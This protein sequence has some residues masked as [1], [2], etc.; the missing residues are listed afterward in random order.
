MK[1]SVRPEREEW[2]RLQRASRVAGESLSRFLIRGGLQLADRVLAGSP[3]GLAL[4]MRDDSEWPKIPG[5]FL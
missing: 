3:E 4:D 1:T 2:R 5:G